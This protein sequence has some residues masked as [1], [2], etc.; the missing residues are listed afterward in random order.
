MLTATEL[1]PHLL[2]EDRLV[3]DAVVEYFKDSWSPDP[4]LVPIVLE[5]VRR[6]GSG[7]SRVG[8]TACPRFRLTD[9]SLEGVLRALAE[10]E[11][12]IAARY[13]N[14]AIGGAPADLLIR[15]EARILDAKGLLSD[16][17][18][19]VHRRR[20]LSAWPAAKLWSELEELALRS[21]ERYVGEIDHAYADDLIDT[22]SGHAE[23]DVAT[24]CE[25]LGPDGVEGWLEI[26]LIDLAGA[27][28][29]GEAIPP[30]IDKFRIDTDYMLERTARALARIGGP[31]A[32]RRIR[33]VF[34]SESWDF[35][36]YA[37]GVLAA[38]KSE[39]SEDALLAVLGTERDEGL[40]TWLCQGLCHQFSHRGLTAVLKEIESGYDES[41]VCLEE[42]VL[43][44]AELLGVEL[45]EADAWRERAE[46]ERAR[47]DRLDLTAPAFDALPDEDDLDLLAD[48]PTTPYRR[49]HPKIGRNA[50]CPCGSGRKFKRC[51]GDP[52]A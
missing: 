41:V 11:G 43:P 30:L 21:Q 29:L 28:R 34:A 31:D 46:Q 24:I 48:F 52:T 20:Q 45:P 35:R 38:I 7:E 18:E 44:A 12:E 36:L 22:L 13:L 6:Y 49:P 32:V 26:F 15:H 47:L 5:A 50:P 14:E 2:H 4:D 51:C 25:L 23:P 33:S 37:S 39:A 8:L 40:R 27:R 3:R 10:F 9:E 16:T 17:G 1:K 19:R 42:E